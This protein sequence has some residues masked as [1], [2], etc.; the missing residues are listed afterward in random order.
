MNFR[1]EVLRVLLLLLIEPTASQ[2]LS[3]EL[4]SI[5][6]K[7]TWESQ[8]QPQDDDDSA[9]TAAASASEDTLHYLSEEMFLLL[10]SVVMA[11]QIRDAI[12][13]G[14]HFI[15]DGGPEILVRETREEH[16]ILRAVADMGAN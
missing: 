12:T 16:E 1:C 9:A 4:T 7:Y 15:G 14:L 11:A 5:L 13:D 3:P 8:Q 6:D 2:T 10:Q